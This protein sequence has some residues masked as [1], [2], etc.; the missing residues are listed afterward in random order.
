MQMEKLR[1]IITG[2]QDEKWFTADIKG[3]GKLNVK[4]N[5][6][7]NQNSNRNDDYKI[8]VLHANPSYKKGIHGMTIN[9]EDRQTDLYDKLVKTIETSQDDMAAETLVDMHIYKLEK[10]IS[11]YPIFK[12]VYRVELAKLKSARA[13]HYN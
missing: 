3:F 7:Y 4:I 1:N 12:D 5:Q 9:D 13:K 11:K 2:S 8:R 6:N 10:N